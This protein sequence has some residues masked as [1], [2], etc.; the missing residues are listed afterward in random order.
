MKITTGRVVLYVLSESD[1][2]AINR[3]RTDGGSIA[4]RIKEDKWPLGAQAHIGNTVTAG[5]ICPAVAIRVW[6]EDENPPVNFHVLL[7]GNDTFWATSRHE[8]GSKSHGT[9]HWPERA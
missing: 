7:D 9:W 8:G 6:S 2:Q 3:R 1:A 5:D 4:S